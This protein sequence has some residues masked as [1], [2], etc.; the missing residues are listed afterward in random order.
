MNIREPAATSPL[1]RRLN[2][3]A[4]LDALRASG[5]AT[6]SELMA[7]T[8]LSRPTVHTVCD[9]LISRGWI[10]EIEQ[11]RPERGS[12]P[13]R[14]ARQYE[15]N[16]T[17]G[18]VLGIDLGQNKVTT[19]VADL[20]GDSLAQHTR[21]FR[22]TNI[23]ARARLNQTHRAIEATLDEAGLDK[24]AVLAIALAVPG[25]VDDR[26][27]IV[28]E[29]DYLPGLAKI[30]LREVVGDGFDAPVLVENDANLAVLAERWRGCAQ[31]ID[32]V[33]ELLAGERL[34]SGLY[35][36]GRLIQGGHGA[37]GELKFLSMVEGVGNTDGIALLARTLGAEAV[38]KAVVEGPAKPSAKAPAR[39]AALV[40][41][42][43]GD[44]DRMTAE[45][46]FVAAS[47]GDPLAL[48]VVD[49]VTGRISR[50]I[51]LLH[52]LLN[53]E[54]VVIGGAVALAG[55]VLLQ[56]LRRAV[57]ELVTDPPK[58]MNSALG[59]H[60]VVTGAVCRALDH[61]ALELFQD[62]HGARNGG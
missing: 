25:P 15:F 41:A 18:F 45:L 17:A 11:R 16:A 60:V 50:V 47:D 24:S 46:L 44:P 40:E 27:H 34:G 22:G 48:A 3:G 10:H 4:V 35:L 9:H 51:A 29:E 62:V 8:G 21:R 6:G 33:V 53:P 12:G 55:D 61:A 39:R 42:V 49:E 1:L 59:D 52:T 23:G 2:A 19:V 57:G 58:I 36:G 13:G 7:T 5:P 20:R 38:A 54:L 14:R 43:D 26:G 28:A 32:N 56:P 30:D 31:D 37:A